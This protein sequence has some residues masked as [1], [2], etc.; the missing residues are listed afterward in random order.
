MQ[1]GIDVANGTLV[2]I[3]GWG[4]DAADNEFGIDTMGVIDQKLFLERADPYIRKLAGNRFEHGLAL[5]Y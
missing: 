5:G 3:I 1:I 2:F 4:A